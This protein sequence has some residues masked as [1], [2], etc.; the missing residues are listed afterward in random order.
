MRGNSVNGT[1]LVVAQD[2]ATAGC[3]LLNA[4]YFAGYWWRRNGSRGRRV[5]ALALVLVSAA[6]VIE[7]VFSQGLFWWQRGVLPGQLSPEAWAVARL[8][9]LL[10]T[11]FISILILRGSR[12]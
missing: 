3:G 6:A 5:G 1:G 9:L 10:A 12:S 4:A 7:A 2:L 8:P 11:L